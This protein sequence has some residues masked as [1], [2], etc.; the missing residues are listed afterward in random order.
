VNNMNSTA[1]RNM[2]TASQQFKFVQ[3]AAGSYFTDAAGGDL[4]VTQGI[5]SKH[6]DQHDQSLAQQA[7]A[8][9]TAQQMMMDALAQARRTVSM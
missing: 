9:N 1:S 5:W 8:T 6:A 3:D 2:D 7:K 4:S